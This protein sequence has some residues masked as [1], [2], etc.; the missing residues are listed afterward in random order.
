MEKISDTI[1]IRTYESGVESE[2]LSCGTGVVAGVLSLFL[3]K[4]IS[5]NKI[6]VQTQGGTLTVSYKHNAKSNT[7]S[8][9]TLS[10]NV[11]RVFEGKITMPKF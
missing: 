6:I 3:Q 11:S 9:I 7:F 2:T 1:L 8:N 4:L 5:K 10:N